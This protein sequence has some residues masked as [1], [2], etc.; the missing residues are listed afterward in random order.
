[1]L[2]MNPKINLNNLLIFSLW[3]ILIILFFTFTNFNKKDIS[4]Y[5]QDIKNNIVQETK[6][7]TKKLD[8]TEK[9]KENFCNKFIKAWKY[10]KIWSDT[11]PKINKTHILCWEINSKWKPTGL[12][13]IYLSNAPATI[14]IKSIKSK[15]NK[16]WVYIASIEI[17]DIKTNKYKTKNSSIFPDNLDNNELEK[18]I[19]N[20]WNNKTYYK[21]SKF[22]WPSWL[23][24]NI[25]WYTYKWNSK[26]NTAY[27]IYTK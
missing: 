20:A 13:S 5:N 1:M 10:Y 15:R 7:E 27:P 23:G 18:I 3:V 25:E 8:I 2:N 9:E 22:K 12:H 26:I 21:N 4:S 24:F 11:N 14:K 16:Y 6:K 17:L 19:I